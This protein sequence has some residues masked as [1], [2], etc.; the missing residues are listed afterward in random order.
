[1]LVIGVILALI[2]LLTAILVMLNS[3]EKCEQRCRY[4]SKTA[5]YL[6]S[7]ECR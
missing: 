1:M 6:C 7:Q 2:T 5:Q 3:D 4:D